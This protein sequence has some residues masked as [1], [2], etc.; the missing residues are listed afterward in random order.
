MRHKIQNVMEHTQLPVLADEFKRSARN[1]GHNTAAPGFRGELGFSDVFF[2]N[3]N[4]VHLKNVGCGDNEVGKGSGLAL[5]GPLRLEIVGLNRWNLGR[6]IGA[7]V[8]DEAGGAV[9]DAGGPMHHLVG[10]VAHDLGF[11]ERRRV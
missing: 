9:L 7:A 10:G 5:G 11:A 8:S 2:L 4:H 6:G 1:S 3:P